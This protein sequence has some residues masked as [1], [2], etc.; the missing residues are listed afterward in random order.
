MDEGRKV[1]DLISMMGE[2]LLMN[3]AEIARV[4]ET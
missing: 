2:N 4:Q 3:G 1:L